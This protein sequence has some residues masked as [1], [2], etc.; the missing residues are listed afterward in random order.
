MQKKM[1]YYDAS[2]KLIYCDMTLLRL[3]KQLKD[4]QQQD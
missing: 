3:T 1:H 2:I 4:N